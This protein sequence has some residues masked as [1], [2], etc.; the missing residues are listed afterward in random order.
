[1]LKL[2]DALAGWTPVDGDRAPDPI[3]LLDAGWREIVGEDVAQNS[4]PARIADRTLTI[5]TRS[6][7]WSHQLSFLSEHVLRAVNARVPAAGVERLRFR[8]G[9]LSQSRSL[10][11]PRSKPNALRPARARRPPTASLGEALTRFRSGVES[12]SRARRAEGWIE[13][14]DCGALLAPGPTRRCAACTVAFAQSREAA[15][16][17]LLYEAPWL[18]FVGTAALVDGLREEEYER[19]RG[20]LLAH[21]WGMLERARAT[22]QLR[23]DGRERLVASSYVLLQSRLAPEAIMPA[24]VRN[25][26]GDELHHLLYETK[27]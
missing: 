22:K 17:R 14:D 2:S 18:G 6:S 8:I 20:R 24:T 21:W 3:V 1:V 23:R 9:R 11:P 27:A 4:R 25:I 7:A 13:C 19:I 15:T 26:L 16:A 10:P 12:R 5:T